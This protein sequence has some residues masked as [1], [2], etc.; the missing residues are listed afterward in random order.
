MRRMGARLRG[1]QMRGLNWYWLRKIICAYWHRC[2]RITPNNHHGPG[3]GVIHSNLCSDWNV[4]RCP[5]QMA[6]R[7]AGL[8]V[9]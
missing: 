5:C 6:A 7:R 2:S 1:T 3:C 4:F 9:T 8:R